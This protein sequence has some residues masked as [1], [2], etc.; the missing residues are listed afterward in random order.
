MSAWIRRYARIGALTALAPFLAG[1]H[2]NEDCA[3]T[4]VKLVGGRNL[5]RTVYGPAVFASRPRVVPLA[6][7]FAPFEKRELRVDASRPVAVVLA[8]SF[9]SRGIWRVDGSKLKVGDRGDGFVVISLLEQAGRV[10]LLPDKVTAGDAERERYDAVVLVPRD[11]RSG[12]WEAAVAVEVGRRVERKNDPDT[13]KCVESGPAAP[14]IPEW[15][16]FS[17]PTRCGDGVRQDDEECDDGNRADGDG[18]ST[19]CFKER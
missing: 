8:S 18:C 10:P 1:A 13:G 9:A 14:P 19:Y 11:R 12:P 16:L 5:E 6:K 4:G 3:Q 17:L 2:C 15:Q 7:L